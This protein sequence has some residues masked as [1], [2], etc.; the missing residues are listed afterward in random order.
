MELARIAA[1]TGGRGSR[2][3]SRPADAAIE[4][5]LF[6]CDGVLVDSES[7][8]ASIL[9]AM[10]DERG[11]TLGFAAALDLLRGR[12]VATW[13]AELFAGSALAG[14]QETFTRDYRAR[15][16]TAY[17]HELQAEPHA[18]ELLDGMDVPYSIVSNAP[19][20]K[21][22]DGLT[23]A[24]LEAGSAHQLV[25]AYDLQSWKPEPTVYLHAAAGLGVAAERC[26]AVED[27]DAGVRAAHAAGMRVIHYTR[28][29]AVPTHP[30]AV[31]RSRHH[32]QTQLIIASLATQGAA[33]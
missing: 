13:V 23:C 31:A 22:R 9:S 10:L 6:D 11:V 33:V 12:K 2:L 25:S 1:D 30:L 28:D 24:R 5:V 8:S 14:S 21:I 32:A 27:S 26:L 7:L 15:V 4:A 18:Q 17:R 19:E 20:W 29:D 16:S 3:P